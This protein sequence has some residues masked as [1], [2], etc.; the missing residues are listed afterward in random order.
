MGVK[1]AVFQSGG[2]ATQHY[3]SG[4]YSRID[5]IRGSG[6]L[7]SINNALI[8][9]DSRG[10]KPNELLWFGSATEAA[11]VLRAGKL[12]DAIKHAFSP[13]GEHVPQKIGAW[14]VNVGT[15]SQHD[16]KESTNE[17]IE[18]KAKDYGLHTNQI[19]TKLE[20]GATGKKVTIQFMDND[21]EVWDNVLKESFKIMYTGAGTDCML[22]ISKTQLSTTCA[23]AGTD[24]LTMLFSVYETIEEMVNYINDQ[25]NYTASILTPTPQDPSTELDSLSSHDILDPAEETV[26]SSLQALIDVLNESA[27]VEANY[28]V[29]AATRALPDNETSWVYFTG[30]VDGT[31]DATAWGVSLGLVEQGDVQF[32]GTSSEDAAIHLLIKTHCVKM[33]S[34][35]G[36][37]ERQFIVGG[38]AGESVAQVLVRAGNLASDAGMLKYP[39]FKH[40]DFNDLS[41]IK[42]WSPAY[43]A[44]KILGMVVCLSIQEPITNKQVD[45]LEWEKKLTITEAETLIKGGV[46]CGILNRSGRKVNARGITTY[47]GNLLQRNEFSMIRIALYASK[48]L[49][50]AIEESFVGKAMSNTLLGKVDGIAVGKLSLYYDMGLFNGNPAYWGYRKTIIGDIVKV[51]YDA[52][53]TPPTNFLFVTSHMHVYASTS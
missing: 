36:K 40:Y 42:T 17:M 47:Q 11:E 19:K 34:T 4:A 2:Q 21:P 41:K 49:R 50:T 8:M 23:G 5:F 28:Y 27:W 24:D 18:C 32:L 53:I 10:G 45:V 44:A 25:T 1:P 20:T 7:V 14:R 26:L 51:D 38:A 46:S 15:R 33:N 30:A 39:G 52:N 29:A 37:N 31:Y 13:G 6:G 9:G 43:Y 3:L 22:V 48:D 12:L 35:T 16:Y